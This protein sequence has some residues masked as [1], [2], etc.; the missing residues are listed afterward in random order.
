MGHRENP[1]LSEAWA[2]D[3]MLVNECL[4]A[5][6]YP[7]LAMR[8]GRKDA[9]LTPDWRCE[10][11]VPSTA[12]GRAIAFPAF[13][14]IP[15]ACP[16]PPLPKE[17]K[18]SRE[19]TAAAQKSAARPTAFVLPDPGRGCTVPI[20]MRCREPARCAWQPAVHET[21]FSF[22]RHVELRP[23]TA[24]AWSHTARVVQRFI[25]LFRG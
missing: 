16:R 25:W 14:N 7:H 5:Q 10:A 15:S 20:S 13:P 24:S 12:S 4:P 2:C 17:E 18:P 8:R 3:A 22:G 1:L 21:P 9:I 23:S 6:G 11:V 19:I